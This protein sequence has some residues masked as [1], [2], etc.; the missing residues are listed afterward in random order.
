LRVDDALRE[1]FAARPGI[2]LDNQYGPSETHVITAHLLDGDPWS[3]PDLPPIG[4]PISNC[5]VLLLDEDGV[6]VPDGDV[7]E[8]YLGGRNLAHGYIG[9]P[10]LTAERF[11]TLRPRA[12]VA[13]T[14]PATSDG[15]T[16]RATSTSRDAPITR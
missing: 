14:E 9:R 3:W 13:T 16:T 10:D 2:T 5:E 4:T 1:V 7:G 8:L 6:P 15:P 12:S 11:V